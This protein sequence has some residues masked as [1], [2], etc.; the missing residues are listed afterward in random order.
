MKKILF[1]AMISFVS[2]AFM[3]CDNAENPQPNSNSYLRIGDLTSLHLISL[4]QAETKLADMGFKGGL[5]SGEDD[6]VYHYTSLDQKESFYFTLN[7]DGFIETISYAASKGIEP[8][9]AIKWLSHIPEKVSLPLWNYTIP[10]VG[11][12]FET[13]TSTEKTCGTYKEYTEYLNNLTSNVWVTAVWEIDEETLSQ[14][15]KVGYGVAIQYSYENNIDQAYLS[16]PCMHRVEPSD[17]PTD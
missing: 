6:E 16:I 2:I 17:P 14:D 5:M 4:S 3:S 11:A 10:F 12:S 7:T 8:K 9:D 15:E 1:Y 13:K